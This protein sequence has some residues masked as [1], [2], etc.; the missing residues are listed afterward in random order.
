MTLETY[1][2]DLATHLQTNGLGV[3][4]VTTTTPATTT[5]ISVSGFH[6]AD[7][8]YIFVT[9]YQG[10]DID[11]LDS[12]EEDDIYPSV[13][14]LVRNSSQTATLAISNAI[15]RMFRKLGNRTIGTTDIIYMRAS[16]PPA[17]VIKSNGG[18]YTYSINFSMRISP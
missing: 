4:E 13:Q 18:Y 6:D 12:G 11:E 5:R 14:F 17:F 1:L 8:N 9:P 2:T 7:G 10:T 15:Y 3:T 16:G